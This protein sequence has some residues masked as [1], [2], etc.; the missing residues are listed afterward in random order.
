MY[1]NIL[2]PTDGSELADKIVKHGSALAQR[3]GAK[4]T[5]LCL[6]G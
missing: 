2:I 6:A 4:V 5:A 3:L 1:S